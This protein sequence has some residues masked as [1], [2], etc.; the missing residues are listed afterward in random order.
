[1]YSCKNYFIEMI[2]G[3]LSISRLSNALSSH[4]PYGCTNTATD[5][6]GHAP[7]VPRMTIR[8]GRIAVSA[9]VTGSLWP[10]AFELQTKLAGCTLARVGHLAAASREL[11]QHEPKHA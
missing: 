8:N 1:M 2:A 3:S 9:R 4:P 10:Q 6:V 5:E 11:G 7:H